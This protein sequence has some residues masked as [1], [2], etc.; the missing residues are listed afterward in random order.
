MNTLSSF[1]LTEESS[2]KL[3]VAWSPLSI[4]IVGTF[5]SISRRHVDIAFIGASFSNTYFIN[6]SFFIL[7]W[8]NCYSKRSLSASMLSSVE[9]RLLSAT[10]AK[11]VSK[12]TSIQGAMKPVE[13][14]LPVSILRYELNTPSLSSQET[15]IPCPLSLLP[16][17]DPPKPRRYPLA[18]FDHVAFATVGRR[19]LFVQ[20]RS[21]VWETHAPFTWKWFGMT[22]KGRENGIFAVLERVEAG[23]DGLRFCL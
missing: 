11:S 16:L 18:F 20:L 3:D 2:S 4:S 8:F 9:K 10:Q 5:F 17:C 6:C 14:P 7:W 12:L 22:G 15:R 19:V 21:L 13:K 1:C 23:K